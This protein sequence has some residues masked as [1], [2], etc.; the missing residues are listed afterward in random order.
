MKL[1]DIILH[2][3][4]TLEEAGFEAYVVGGCVRDYL[5]NQDPSDYDVCTSARPEQVMALFEHTVPTGINHGTVSVLMPEPIEVTTFRTE[6]SYSDHRHPDQVCFVSNI[7]EDLARRDFTINAMA[8]HPQKGII[9]PFGGQEDLKHKLV[10]CVGNPY[11]RFEEDALR[12]L[13][14]YRFCAKLGFAME[15]KSEEALK[16][17]H[18]QLSFVAVERIYTELTK[19][20]AY[21]P[22][23]LE[24]M[25]D[26]LSPWIPELKECALCQQNTVWH[27]SNVLHHTCKAISYLRPF[28]E[29]LAY[30]LLFHDLGKPQTKTTKDGQ[31]HFYAHP[32][33]SAQIASRIMKTLRF[34]KLSSRRILDLVYYHDADLSL[35]LKTIHFFRVELGWSDEKMQDLFTIRYCDLMAHS[36][37]GQKSYAQ[38]EAFKLF[39]LKNKNRPM[40]ISDLA[41]NGRD[42][43]EYTLIRGKDI[44]NALNRLLSEV[45]Y[46]P[47]WNTKEKLLEMLG[48]DKNG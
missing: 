11:K 20:L 8:Y 40:Q 3:L 26:L 42:I 18:K 24:N 4:T 5:L 46:H 39:Y 16:K 27:D 13:R 10:R 36:A 45:F 15:A 19:I 35:R 41:I 2:V 34:R 9:D 28:D 22:F 1:P 47:E 23:Q 29:D 43:L 48:G 7:E 37:K 21:D 38:V 6:S 31:D 17:L 25:T 44:S 14:A 33:Y 32:R 30:V 12:M